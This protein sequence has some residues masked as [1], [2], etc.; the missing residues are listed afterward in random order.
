MVQNILR[1]MKPRRKKYER[2]DREVSIIAT[3]LEILEIE[4]YIIPRTL[5][6]LE[7]QCL[8]LFPIVAKA[9]LR[10]PV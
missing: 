5:E 1:N 2:M 6:I 8:Y 10:T 3:I 9:R 7:I 4:I